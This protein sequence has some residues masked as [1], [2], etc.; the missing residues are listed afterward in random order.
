[1]TCPNYQ[2]QIA[3]RLPCF[4]STYYMPDTLLDPRMIHTAQAWPLPS[5]GSPISCKADTNFKVKGSKNSS[6]ELNSGLQEQFPPCTL[7]SFP[8]FNA[9]KGHAVP[10]CPQTG[11]LLGLGL[12]TLYHPETRVEPG[13]EWVLAGGRSFE[14]GLPGNLSPSHASP[15]A[16]SS[17]R[18]E[19]GS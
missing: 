17:P 5:R 1:M 19:P 4:L 9:R 6:R 3:A 2:Q 7:R 13:S 16:S 11:W 18:G 8:H 15:P 12:G 10:D 14:A